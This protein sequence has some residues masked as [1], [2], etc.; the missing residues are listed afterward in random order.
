LND[1]QTISPPPAPVKPLLSAKEK[2]FL[3]LLADL[4]TKK[5]LGSCHPERS[6]G[7]TLDKTNGT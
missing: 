3:D 1:Q 7:T 2:S 5:I 6:E 4:F